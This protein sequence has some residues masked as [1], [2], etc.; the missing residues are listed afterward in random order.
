MTSEL[1]GGATE[2]T[3]SV[4]SADSYYL[5]VPSTGISEGSYGTDSQGV[6]RPAASFISVCRQ[7]IVAGYQ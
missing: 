6:P 7:Q 5:V 3:L 4:S 1:P 2:T